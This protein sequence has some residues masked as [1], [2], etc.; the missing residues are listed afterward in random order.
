MYICT[1]WIIS[2]VGEWL[3]VGAFD[4]VV[5]IPVM[6]NNYLY[7]FKLYQRVYCEQVET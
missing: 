6:T 7:M 1:V 3:Q 4:V 5:R 2:V